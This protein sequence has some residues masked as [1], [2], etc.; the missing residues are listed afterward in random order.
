MK[1]SQGRRPRGRK[2]TATLVSILAAGLAGFLVMLV[3]VLLRPVDP[4]VAQAG[5]AS[6]EAREH[7]RRGTELARQGLFDGAAATY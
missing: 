1:L 4:A 2:H 3:I 6:V 7:L 5:S